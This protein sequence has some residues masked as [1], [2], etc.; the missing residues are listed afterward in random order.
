MMLSV[1]VFSLGVVSV[2]SACSFGARRVVSTGSA[3][4]LWAGDYDGDGLAAEVVAA[5]ATEVKVFQLR[6]ETWRTLRTF[7]VAGVVSMAVADLNGDGAADVA[8]AT[9]SGA[10]V[11]WND[12]NVTSLVSNEPGI[13][14]ALWDM[15]ADEDLDVVVAFAN[16]TTSW[17]ENLGGSFTS[18]QDV[19][20]LEDTETVVA[21]GSD[22]SALAMGLSDGSIYI[23][24]DASEKTFLGS[25]FGPLQSVRVVDATIVAASLR[26]D[27]VAFLTENSVRVA[28]E[29]A[30][31]VV[32][33]YAADFDAD[34]D[35]DAVSACFDDATV[36]K[37]SDAGDGTFT[38]ATVDDDATGVTKVYAA[39]ID[40]DSALDVVAAL[41][42]EV[43]W[44][45]NID[46]V[47]SPSDGSKKKKKKK[48]LPLGVILV[49][50]IVA[51]LAFFAAVV[52]FTMNYDSLK[53]NISK[54]IRRVTSRR[55]RR[56]L[57]PPE[58]NT[59]ETP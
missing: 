37:H 28:S 38:T 7:G 49:F 40:G 13:S 3:S 25:F 34:G 47:L 24:E 29:S 39:D 31:G 42:D 59:E 20:F 10:S 19:A 56:Q 1:L 11:L 44:Y 23:S 36:R 2:W 9:D 4:A 43:V 46:C 14:V 57:P 50:T 6:D 17:F 45:Q 35:I 52:F 16:G 32:D 58:V 30:H 8:V 15:D 22:S 51:S 5:E 54:S 55:R 27:T 33:V 53:K 21:L 48:N 41:E 26:D 18:R 12:E